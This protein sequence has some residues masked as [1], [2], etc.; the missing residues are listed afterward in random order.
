MDILT[1]AL[2]GAVIA[3]GVASVGNSG[4]LYRIGLVAA[5]IWGGILP[6][7]DAISMWSHFDATFGRFFGLAHSGR[8]IY[9]AKLWY[10]HHA[11]FHS[12]AASILFG[13]L[14]LCTFYLISRLQTRHT[15]SLLEYFKVNVTLFT[16]FVFGYWA[17]LAGDLPTPASVWGGMN[18]FWP[19]PGYIGGYGKT[20]WWNNYDVFLILL[21]FFIVN[22]L[23]LTIPRAITHGIRRFSG[24]LIVFAFIM[25]LI[26]FNTRKTDYRYIGNTNKYS[27][28]EEQSKKEQERILPSGLYRSMDAFDQWLKINF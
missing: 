26:Q 5:G 28:F 16:A 23:T 20:W 10:S 17:H 24:A 1:H 15:L 13:L 8:A 18:L 6:D 19:L 14:F 22:M 12:I 27:V 21:F 2:S 25:V 11:F 7:L 4:L 9:G 3:T